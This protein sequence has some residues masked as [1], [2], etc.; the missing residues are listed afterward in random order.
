[1]DHCDPPIID[2]NTLLDADAFAEPE[3][4]EAH[5]GEVV[6]LSSWRVKLTGSASHGGHE[7]ES[8]ATRVDGDG[9]ELQGVGPDEL[10]PWVW[11][12]VASPDGESV[13][14][15]G[16]VLPRRDPAALAIDIK[17]K[18]LFP[19]NRVRLHRALNRG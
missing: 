11:V 16:Q 19:D 3:A 6:E 10:G 5:G 17:F 13:R 15:L 12:D 4:P 1:M 18:H 8:E 9:V 7:I 14:A 2:S